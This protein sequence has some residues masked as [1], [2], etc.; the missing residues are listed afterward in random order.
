L[1]L[2]ADYRVPII[3]LVVGNRSALDI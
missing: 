1:L 3:G 2:L